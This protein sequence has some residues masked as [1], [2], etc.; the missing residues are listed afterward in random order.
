MKAKL[1]A[2]LLL[3]STWMIAQAAPGEPRFRE[4]EAQLARRPPIKAPTVLLYGAD[5]GVAPPSREASPGERTVIP[6]LVARRVI[7]GAGHFLPRERPDVVAS[8]VQEVVQ[9]SQR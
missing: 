4:I 1:T 2:S 8:A 3:A 9:A 5:D 6:S 7:D